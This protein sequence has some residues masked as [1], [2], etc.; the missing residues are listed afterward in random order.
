MGGISDEFARSRK[1]L[2]R[3]LVWQRHMDNKRLDCRGTC[4]GLIPWLLF[5]AMSLRALILYPGGR[6]RAWVGS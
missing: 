6:L 2:L 5:K 3:S 1:D 4:F